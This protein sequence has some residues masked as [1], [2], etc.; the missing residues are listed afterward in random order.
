MPIGPR[1]G[2]P[3]DGDIGGSVKPVTDSS[4]CR[5]SARRCKVTVLGGGDVGTLDT[6][7]AIPD[8]P[9]MGGVSAHGPDGSR[10]FMRS[11]MVCMVLSRAVLLA[12][13]C[14]SCRP[15]PARVCFVRKSS[16]PQIEWPPSAKVSL[17][18]ELMASA[19][20]EDGVP[21]EFVVGD[22]HGI[23]VGKGR[24]SGL[25][26]IEVVMGGEDPNAEMPM[27]VALHGR[28]DRPRIPGGP[29]Y[30]LPHPVRVI[31]PRG[32]IK[33]GSGFAWLPVGVS[34]GKTELL[35]E[36]LEAM[37]DRLADFMVLMRQTRPTAG[38]TIVTGFS[39]GGHLCLAMALLHPFEVG[40]AIPLAGWLPP[41]IVPGSIE[42]PAVYPPIRSIHGTRDLIVR[43][44]PTVAVLDGLVALGLDVE[45]AKFE[46]VGHV[47]THEMDALFHEWLS[48]ELIDIMGPPSLPPAKE[49]EPLGE[50][51]LD[52][53]AARDTDGYP[54]AETDRLDVLA[55]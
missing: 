54:E 25:S 29:F 31:V 1:G 22:S 42:D 27:V 48:D 17:E 6:D 15:E 23:W 36:S 53:C 43:I 28:G 3:H 19:L 10:L 50:E 51:P 44:G 4:S 37:A 12:V 9:A 33:H 40:L 49:C 38:G 45:I 14:V 46:G 16:R 8:N 26:F 34:Q 11:K 21:G 41:G 39:Q 2:D 55:I 32:P 35:A 18:A 20:D 13:V 7:V 30:D 47:M 5:R 24:A 52:A